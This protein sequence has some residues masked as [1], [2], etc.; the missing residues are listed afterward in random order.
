MP[1]FFFFLP[2]FKWNLSVALKWLKMVP[3]NTIPSQLSIHL[4]WLTVMVDLYFLYLNWNFHL[5]NF[6]GEILLFLFIELSTNEEFSFCVAQLEF[7]P[8]KKVKIGRL[9]IFIKKTSYWNVYKIPKYL[10]FSLL[11]NLWVVEQC[12]N[13]KRKI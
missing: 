12:N 13:E 5:T 3:V 11:K 4:W 9:S 7:M 6:E 10:I 1:D 8:K 2:E